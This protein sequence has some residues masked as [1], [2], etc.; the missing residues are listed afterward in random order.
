MNGM[1]WMDNDG[2]IMYGRY[3]PRSRIDRSGMQLGIQIDVA[4]NNLIQ[5]VESLVDGC[6]IISSTT[7]TADAAA[8]DANLVLVLV[9]RVL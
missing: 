2:W 8:A 5:V 6:I 4:I 1:G 7:T 3:N 9:L